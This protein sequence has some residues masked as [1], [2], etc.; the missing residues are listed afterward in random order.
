MALTLNNNLSKLKVGDY[1]WCKYTVATAN[2]VGVFSDIATKTDAE[3]I[4]VIPVAS[5]ATPN[6]YFR[7]IMVE[8]WNG[9]K[10]LLADRNIQHS[11]SLD[12][13]NSRGIASGSG[14]PNMLPEISDGTG[15]KHTFATR[16][17]TGGTVSTD[18]DNE[19]DK[20]IV[21][22]TLGGTITAGDNNVWNFGIYSWTST[23]LSTDS[24]KR[25]IRGST[26]TSSSN[27]VTSDAT[28]A[29]RPVLEIESLFTLLNK[30]F[31][32]LS[33]GY[34]KLS[35]GSPAITNSAIPVM[36]SKTTPSGTVTAST[37]RSELYGMYKAFDGSYDTIWQPVGIVGWLMYQFTLPKKIVKYSVSSST[38]AGTET[39]Y[40]KSWTFEGS[41]DGI[42]FDVL[43]TQSNITGWILSQTKT[44]DINNVKT[45][46]YYRINVSLHNGG[47]YLAIG[48]LSMFETPTPAIP[49]SFK[50]V[51]PTLPTLP[52][53][54]TEGMDDLSIFD[55]K[56][57]K[58][59]ESPKGMTSEVLGAGKV[60]K[61]SVDLKKI[62]DL[63]KLEVK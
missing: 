43:D 39:M 57:Q 42:L 11:L 6:G 46:L 7:F 55:R 58:V 29:F 56:V 44:F 10:I 12:V 13:L 38:I 60:Y 20:Y 37:E 9:K 48:E 51:S 16:L 26:S 32:L 41:N 24:T 18:K 30:S 53:F 22:S 3:A 40:P 49:P 14:L 19:W 45:Y 36:T 54:Q 47:S 1:F 63:R 28:R 52:Q 8:D 2:T 34:K 5:S 23:T 62:F 50:T 59:L 31:I 27:V 61:S 33:D 15:L 35:Q 4:P 21:G 17:L 25:I